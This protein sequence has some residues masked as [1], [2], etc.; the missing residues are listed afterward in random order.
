M[1]AINFI[2]G[3]SLGVVTDWE[4]S[5]DIFIMPLSFPGQDTGA[6]QAIDTLGVIGK[7]KITGYLTGTFETLQNSIKSIKALADGFQTASFELQSP[8]VNASYYVGGTGG[9]KTYRNGHIGITTSTSA[10]TLGDSN[11]HFTTW[12]IQSGD[13]AKNLQTGSV[14]NITSVTAGTLYLDADIFPVAGG[15]GIPYAVTATINVKITNFEVR[16]ETPGLS[17]V[18]Y[19]LEVVQVAE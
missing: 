10:N 14:A 17:Y 2:S 1:A 9:T 3:L 8:F 4:D 19:E 16:W 5:K 15:S 11:A 7:I 12:N 13:V 6:T 18:Y